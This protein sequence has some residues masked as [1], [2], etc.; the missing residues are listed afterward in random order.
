LRVYSSLSFCHLNRPIGWNG[1][2]SARSTVPSSAAKRARQLPTRLT[3]PFAHLP[4][5]RLDQP[6][7]LFQ[8]RYPLERRF[9]RTHIVSETAPDDAPAFADL[10]PSVEAQPVVQFQ[11]EIEK[12]LR[13]IVSILQNECQRLSRAFW[14]CEAAAGVGAL[15]VTT[16]ERITVA[17]SPATRRAVV[18]MVHS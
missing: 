8:C 15:V 10:H 18:F 7:G 9:D 16:P 5:V 4:D 11:H 6:P 13:A 1:S 2:A 12:R 14:R 3:P 17:N